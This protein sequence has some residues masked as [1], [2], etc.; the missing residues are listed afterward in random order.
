MKTIEL[1]Q[2]YVTEVDDKN[3]DRCMDGTKWQAEVVKCK[4]GFFNVYAKR[5][6]YIGNGKQTTQKI[7]R[8]ILGITDTKIKV[9]HEDHNGLNNQ[10]YN[11][12]VANDEENAQNRLLPSNNTSGYKGV[13]WNKACQKWQ[14]QIRVYGEQMHLGLFTDVLEAT[15][16]YDAAALR[17]HGKFAY[18]NAM[19]EQIKQ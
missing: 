13:Y 4:E 7:H 8:F 15:A 1:S 3:Y 9:D 12:R 10:E 14:A 2:G 19:M 5:N 11:I 18:T 16:A 6:L 17:Y